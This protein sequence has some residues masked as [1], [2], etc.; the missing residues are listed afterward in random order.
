ME[1]LPNCSVLDLIF[2]S[3]EFGTTAYDFHSH[4]DNHAG[5]LVLIKA[6]KGS[7][8]F[9]GY[10]FQPW[11]RDSTEDY[12]PSPISH[13]KDPFAFLFTLANLFAIPPTKYPIQPD[14]TEFAIR[15]N[16]SISCGFG[17]KS[18]LV[19]GT[20]F[21]WKISSSSATF[22]ETYMDT[23]GKGAV[24]FTGCPTFSVEEVLVFWVLGSPW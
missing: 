7:C 18:D 13:Q 16:H 2:D 21:N 10:T 12:S 20:D 22:G 24:T 9:G 8:L 1:W 5:A 19:L 11:R 14:K 4:C 17:A 6:K 3:K 23:T 15:N